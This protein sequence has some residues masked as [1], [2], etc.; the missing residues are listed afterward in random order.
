MPL[1]KRGGVWWFNYWHEG[2]HIQKSTNQGNKN[3]ARHME[4]AFHTALV[5]GEVGITERKK[6]PSFKV[7]MAE[8]LKWSQKEHKPSTHRR[9]RVSEVALSRHFSRF[10]SL[11]RITPDEVESSSHIGE[12]SSRRYERNSTANTPNRR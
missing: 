4:A 10:E 3:V 1:Y 11:D 2:K 5:K 12:I 7:A 6:I 8:F 9:Y